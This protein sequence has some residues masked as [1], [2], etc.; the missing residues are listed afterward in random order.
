M[1]NFIENKIC[2]KKFQAT[3]YDLNLILS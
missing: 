2:I 1:K 3:F